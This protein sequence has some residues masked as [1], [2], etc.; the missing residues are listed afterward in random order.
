MMNLSGCRNQ[1]YNPRDRDFLHIS[2][3]LPGT[4]EYDNSIQS[5]KCNY[6]DYSN[7][8]YVFPSFQCELSGV[9][10]HFIKLHRTCH[11]RM[12]KNGDMITSHCI[13]IALYGYFGCAVAH[14]CEL[15]DYKELN[16]FWDLQ[17]T[18][19]ELFISTWCYAMV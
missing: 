7:M 8:Y 16:H 6:C 11:E 3:H 4:W 2:S 17:E 19:Y 12:D 14:H 10:L 5:Y 15:Y 9:H 13:D 18:D 1:S